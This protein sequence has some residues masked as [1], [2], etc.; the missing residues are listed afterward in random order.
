MASIELAVCPLLYCI[1]VR[2]LRYLRTPIIMY[3]NR[4]HTILY[5]F[6]NH[7]PPILKYHIFIIFQIFLR[8]ALRVKTKHNILKYRPTFIYSLASELSPV[9]F[10]WNIIGLRD[11]FRLEEGIPKPVNGDQVGWVCVVFG[12]TEVPEG[13]VGVI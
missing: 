4:S 11:S 5:I 13:F 12:T 8:I 9:A 3:H 10:F 7:I 1:I 6:I 2:P